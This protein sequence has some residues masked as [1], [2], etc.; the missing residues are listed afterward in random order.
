MYKAYNINLKKCELIE[1]DGLYFLRTIYE[2]END[3]GKYELYIPKMFLGVEKRVLPDIR[4][5][6][7]FGVTEHFAYI[8][9]NRFCLAEDVVICNNLRN[10]T[11]ENKCTHLI[12]T[13]EEKRHEMT[14]EQI[15]RELGYKVKIVSEKGE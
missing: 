12:R 13:I 7:S 5:E 1:D 4:S 3:K 6:C 11:V 15:E 10:E 14:L 8:F 2:Y 9:G